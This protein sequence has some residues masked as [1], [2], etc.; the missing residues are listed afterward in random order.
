MRLVY[1]RSSAAIANSENTARMIKSVGWLRGDVHVVYP[2]VDA[3]RFHPRADD[4]VLRRRV[5]REGEI[6]LLSVSRL[7]K[8]KGHDLVLKAL[9]ELMRHV[10]GIRYVIVGAGGERESL[11]RLVVDLGLSR[12]VQFEGEVPDNE[13]PA[14]FSACDIFVL[15]TR[16][17]PHDFEGFGLVYLEAAAAGRPT[18]GGRNGGVPEAIVDR[19]T[20][21]LVSGEDVEELVRT[22]RALC[23]DESLRLRLGRAGRER[24]LRD[25]SWERAA[26]QVTSIHWRLTSV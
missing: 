18:I 12:V 26:A 1:R 19:E 23:E 20:G 4:G 14:Y 13:L 17:E 2:G 7:Q 24:A 5:A 15:P 25:F 9:P 10:S 11:E 8:R 22:L 6:L 16:V 3:A 21:L